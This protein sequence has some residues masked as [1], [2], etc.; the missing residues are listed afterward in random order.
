MY[1]TLILMSVFT[2]IFSRKK[3]DE[4]LLVILGNPS[5][6][7][8]HKTLEEFYR[9]KRRLLIRYIENN[10]C[11][12]TDKKKVAEDIFQRVIIVFLRKVEMGKID[13]TKGSIEAL[14][15]GIAKKIIKQYCTRLPGLDS[16]DKIDTNQ[17]KENEIYP[18]SI[19]IKKL[20]LLAKTEN[21]ITEI[22][23]Q[24][25][26][27]NEIEGET[28]EVIAKKLAISVFMSRQHKTKVHFVLMYL[29]V[30]ENC[31]LTPLEL[32]A[33]VQGKSKKQSLSK[34]VKDLTQ[35]EIEALLA[36]ANEKIK[37]FLKAELWD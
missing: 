37:A 10:L 26:V 35:T 32:A 4:E 6:S 20:L 15:Y 8:Y 2:A 25:Y 23:V 31:M 27:L 29:C 19:D 33:W 12:C 16:I 30:R 1:K 28:H 11:D 21:L 13:L 14:L 9:L 7:L 22:E 36:A 5:Q 18:K 24:V 3:T 34:I 17:V